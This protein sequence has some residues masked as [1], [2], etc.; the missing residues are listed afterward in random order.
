M[1]IYIIYKFISSFPVLFLSALALQFLFTF[2][3]LLPL[4]NSLCS[5]H[6]HYLPQTT[7][8][9]HGQL[10]CSKLGPYQPFLD[11]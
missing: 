2:T 3:F 7:F 1:G 5:S 11:E 9:S 10:H 4:V 6:R 8:S